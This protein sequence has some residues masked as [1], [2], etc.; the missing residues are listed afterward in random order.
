VAGAYSST[1]DLIFVHAVA[2]WSI[3]FDLQA[4]EVVGT[5]TQLNPQHDLSVPWHNSPYSFSDEGSLIFLPEPPEHEPQRALVWVE[6]SVAAPHASHLAPRVSPDGTRIAVTGTLDDN[7]Y[8]WIHEIAR[9]GSL[10]RLTFDPAVD[11]G[12]AW[13]PDSKTFVFGSFRSG[14][15]DL[16]ARSADGTGNATPVYSNSRPISPSSVSSDGKYLTYSELTNGWDVGLYSFEEGT[17]K[18]FLNTGFT[19][20]EASIFGLAKTIARQNPSTPMQ[21]PHP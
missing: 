7:S 1:G 19:E 12:N 21:P 2:L 13:L 18:P 8:I 5:E 17:A 4:R 9:P 14:T 15:L 6:E 20:A 11:R 10:T 16:L 3:P